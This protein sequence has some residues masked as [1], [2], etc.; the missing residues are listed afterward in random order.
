MVTKIVKNVAVTSSELLRYEQLIRLHPAEEK[1][2]VYHAQ[3]LYKVFSCSKPSF[4][5]RVL[6][7]G[8]L[9]FVRQF[10]VK[11]SGYVV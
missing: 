6:G 9:G 5:E 2:R 7:G 8:T 10:D 11:L 4:T 3:A 1:Y